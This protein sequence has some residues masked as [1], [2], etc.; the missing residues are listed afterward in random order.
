MQ[1]ITELKIIRNKLDNNHRYGTL[2]ITI[3]GLLLL[4]GVLSLLIFKFQN[5]LLYILY[6]G[7]GI[8][9]IF[10]LIWTRSS[11]QS[12]EDMEDIDEFMNY[13]TLYKLQKG[14]Q[15]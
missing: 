5:K 13:Y 8:I 10:I 3:N 14:K 7:I 9:V 1:H 15:K 2:Q 12:K 6:I 11:I 4:L